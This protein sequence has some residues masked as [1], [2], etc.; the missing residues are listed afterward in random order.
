M[1]EMGKILKNGQ[2]EQ[3]RSDVGMIGGDSPTRSTGEASLQG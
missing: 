3:G 1:E 2:Q